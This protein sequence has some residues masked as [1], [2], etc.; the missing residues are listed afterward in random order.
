RHT[1]HDRGGGYGFGLKVAP[2]P[3]EPDPGERPLRIQAGAELF[4]PSDACGD[5]LCSLVTV[6]GDSLSD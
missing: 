1:L 3:A 4:D 5:D 2:S 6:H